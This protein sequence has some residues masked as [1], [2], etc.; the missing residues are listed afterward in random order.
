MYVYITKFRVKKFRLGYIF[1]N[2][3]A[4]RKNFSPLF[5]LFKTFA[6]SMNIEVR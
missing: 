5:N 2:H 1:R 6:K 3:R 4:Y